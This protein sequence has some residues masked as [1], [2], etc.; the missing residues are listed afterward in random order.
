[1]SLF[2]EMNQSQVVSAMLKQRSEAAARSP[3]C[4]FGPGSDGQDSLSLQARVTVI[5]CVTTGSPPVHSAM[6]QIFFAKPRKRCKCE[7]KLFCLRENDTL[8]L[9]HEVGCHREDLGALLPTGLDTLVPTC[10]LSSEAGQ[11]RRK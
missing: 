10:A 2:W 7:H 4:T 3:S 11:Q 5:C 9:L 8:D 6:L 1:M